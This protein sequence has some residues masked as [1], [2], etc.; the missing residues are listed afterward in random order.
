MEAYVRVKFIV[1]YVCVYV[2]REY[3]LNESWTFP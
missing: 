2:Y 3:E 1:M